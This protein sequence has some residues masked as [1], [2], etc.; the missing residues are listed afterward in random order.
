VLPEPLAIGASVTRYA[1][2]SVAVHLASPAPRGSALIVSE[3][4]YPGWQ[5]TVAGKPAVIGRADF[6]LIGVQLPEGATDID[7]RF[8]SPTYLTGKVITLIALTVALLMIGAGAVAER[9]KVA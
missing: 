8:T 6:T 5:A 2:G 3:N 4:Y 7:L 9:R 1:P